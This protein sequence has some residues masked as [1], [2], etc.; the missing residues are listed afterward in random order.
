MASFKE[1]S[2]I[3]IGFDKNEI[4]DKKVCFLIASYNRIENDLAYSIMYKMHFLPY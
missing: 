3:V 1:V 4:E 2:V